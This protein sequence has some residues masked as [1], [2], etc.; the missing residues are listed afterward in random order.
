MLVASA[1]GSPDSVRRQLAALVEQ[2]GAD[3]LILTAQIFDHHARRRSFEIVAQ[4]WGLA[5]ADTPA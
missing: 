5:P 1:V 4:A 3:E 2:T